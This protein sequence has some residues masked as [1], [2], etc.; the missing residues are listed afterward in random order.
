MDELKHIGVAR[1]SGRYPWGSGKDGYQR[2]TSIR[3]HVNALKKQGLTE[4]QIAE[5]L[6]Y[7]KKGTSKLRADIS[8]EKAAQRQADSAFA[9]R[10][11]DKGYSYTE[12][13]KRMGKNE[14]SVRS[15]LDP[16]MQERALITEHTADMLRRQVAEK[17]YLDV[18]AGIENQ[19]GVSRTRLN[20]SIAQLQ[21]DGYKL[22]YI[23]E[24]QPGT[25]KYTTIKV[26][27]KDDV[28]YK[29]LYQNKDKIR[30]ITEWS[31]DGG[32][33]Y[34]GL[35]PIANISKNRISVKYAEDGGADMDG[36]IQLRRGVNDISLGDKRYAQVRIG[37]EGT[38]YLKGMAIYADDLP[39]GVDIVFN[40]NKKKGTPMMGDKK[41]T[42]LKNVEDSQNNPFG[43]TVR[44]KKYIDSDGKEKLSA[45]NIVYEEGDWNT[46]EKTLSS[47]MLS[48]QTPELAKQQ[49]NLALKIKQDE[50]DEYNSLTNPTVKR[51]LLETFADECDADA[52]HLKA[53]ALPRQ[54]SY[55]IL[56]STKLKPNEIYA[57]NY[58][59]GEKVVLIRYPHAGTFEIPELI[60]N[61]SNSSAKKI[62]ENAIDA[63]AINPLVAK[64][65]SGA[66][67][68]GDSVLV[69]PNPPSKNKIV[70][71]DPI[72][73]LLEFDPRES[74]P[75][76]DGMKRM[77]ASQKGAEMGK[78][79]N[80]ITDMTI[81][82]ATRDE[83]AR[84]VK[85]SMV[86]I[87]AEKHG[88]NYKQSFIDN[89]IAELKKTYQGGEMRGASTLI[90]KAGADFWV[91]RRQDKYA[92]DP[93]SGKKIFK[94]TDEK[95]HYIKDPNNPSKKLYVNYPKIDTKKV[96]P[97]TGKKIFKT[98]YDNPYFVDPKTKARI[99]VSPNQVKEINRRTK[100]TRMYEEDDAY[101]LSSGTRIESIYANHANALKGLGDKARKTAI[102]TPPLKYSP[103]AKKA[104]APEVASLLADLSIAIS[105]KPAERQA[106]LLANKVIK[107]ERQAN[108]QLE[109]P[110]LKKIRGQALAEAR[111]RVGAKKQ[112]INITPKQW[113]A[114]QAGAISN[115]VLKEIL[116]NAKL[117]QIKQYSSPRKDNKLSTAKVNRAKLLFD[118]GYTQ[119]EVASMLGTTPSILIDSIKGG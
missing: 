63:V 96:D 23:R 9:Q 103:S 82:G 70:S 102:N 47:Q 17:G 42:V 105:N 8:L 1:R 15:L 107:T 26:L 38:H 94:Y 58:K 66:D 112:S 39:D 13:G 119:A 56:P 49:L 3:G 118:R 41:S 61:N 77:T 109:P 81:K 7:G 93:K 99:P 10:L 54:G 55:V 50:F 104:Y 85:H 25:G 115:N 33:S 52:V 88:L 2:N 29:T 53:A 89:G 69:I 14:S 106:I 16:V 19:V 30:G 24:E 73:T 12:I 72:K 20:T 6:G 83:I 22:Q 98:D 28:D 95:L 21:K 100:S 43:S 75:S 64:R 4:S 97:I 87:D 44:Q 116:N 117:E 46:W 111:H 5:G 36:V 60:V 27:T 86:V 113:E 84:A 45:L 110:T 68:D 101:N 79:S 62:F 11:K 114:I 71:R 37:V 51:K 92:V 65:L 32:R 34:L 108:P 31:E 78:I 74:Y 18:G 67:F 57:P 35:E 59:N 80:L 90:S 40:T 48:K 76:F 91:D